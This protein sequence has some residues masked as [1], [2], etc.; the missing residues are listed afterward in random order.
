MGVAVGKYFPSDEFEQVKMSTVPKESNDPLVIHWGGMAI[1]APDGS[2]LDCREVI[3]TEIDLD[4]EFA[5]EVTVFGVDLG[6]YAQLFEDQ[7]KA[8]EKSLNGS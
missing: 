1:H 5:Y 3:V 4:D 6:L 2:K 7:I 8:H